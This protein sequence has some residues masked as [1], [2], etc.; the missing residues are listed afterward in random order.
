VFT[1]NWFNY[2]MVRTLSACIMLHII[3]AVSSFF[4]NKIKKHEPNAH[5]YLYSIIDVLKIYQMVCSG[6]FISFDPSIII[7]LVVSIT[8]CGRI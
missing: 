6:L 3:T 8:L 7:I 1:Y 2:W 4:W 5:S